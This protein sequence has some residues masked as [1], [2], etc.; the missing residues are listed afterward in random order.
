MINLTELIKVSSDTV[1]TLTNVMGL[2]EQNFDSYHS[3][4]DKAQANRDSEVIEDLLARLV[5]WRSMNRNTLW[6]LASLRD[7]QK[8]GVED[9]LQLD[10]A[11]GQDF[12]D[13]LSVLNDTKQFLID[14]H[15]SVIRRDHRLYSDLESAVNS[16][17]L[18][19]AAH[20][21][22]KLGSL[23]GEDLDKLHGMYQALLTALDGYKDRLQAALSK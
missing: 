17:I 12:G 18:V 3:I 21:S 10:D 14:N 16:R 1:K 22:G 15:M 5:R 13:F 7:K 4:S 2:V 8:G 20:N 23:S 19:V 11:V 6:R 9:H